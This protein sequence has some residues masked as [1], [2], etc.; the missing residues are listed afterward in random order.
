MKLRHPGRFAALAVLGTVPTL[1][2][3]APAYAA[4]GVTR[5]GAQITANAANNRANNI[6]ITRV[7]ANFVLR[8]LG[9]TMT[10]GPG[11]VRIAANAVRC[12]AAGITRLA[13]NTGNLNDRVNNTTTTTGLL[14][15]GPGND[16]LIG[17][18]GSDVLT[19]GFGNDTMIGNRGNDRA[20]A[21]AVRDGRD[22][23]NGGAGRDTTDY[24]LRVIAVNVTL[25]NAPNDGSAPEGDNNLSN[26]ENAIGG[27][28]GDRLTGNAAGNVLDGRGG[29]DTLTGR[30]GNDTLVGGPGNDGLIGGNGNDTVIGG[31]GNDTLVGGTGNDT[32][33]ALS[34]PDGRDNFSGG[35]GT[36]TTDYAARGIPVNVTLNSVA[37][38]GSGPEGDNNQNNVENA[39]G[40]RAA[41]RLTGNALANNLQGRNGNDVLTGGN[42][43]DTLTGGAGN[44][45]MFG[46]AGQ[47][48]LQAVDGQRDRADGGANVDDCN[49]DAIDIRVSCEL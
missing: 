16:V 13:V 23:F 27:R 30:D 1:L 44:D 42:G 28:A 15:G 47:D 35:A 14:T 40:G 38:D 41:D 37:N 21:E 10:A 11:C 34:T 36:D 32:A 18:P 26:V 4:T 6:T 8:D 7:G 33:V 9:D 25:D 5:A 29:N 43:R 3:A 48:L 19:G 2:M 17:G 46:Q 12:P 24:R 49:T 45:Q 31:A 22:T 20:V 39:I